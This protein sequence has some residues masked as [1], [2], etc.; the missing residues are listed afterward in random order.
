MKA[1][2]TLG[3]VWKINQQ[4]GEK[5]PVLRGGGKL[6]RLFLAIISKIREKVSN[7]LVLWFRRFAGRMLKVATGFFDWSMDKVF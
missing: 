1:M 3:R 7:E 2:R 6:T 4:A 5:Q